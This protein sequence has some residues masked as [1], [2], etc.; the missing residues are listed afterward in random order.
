MNTPFRLSLRTVAGLVLLGASITAASTAALAAAG[1]KFFLD[2]PLAREPDPGDASHVQPFPVHLTWDLVSSLFVN[3]LQFGPKEDFD[4][5]P[6]TFESDCAKMDG[7]G[8]AHLLAPDEREM[9]PTRQ[10]YHV[11]PDPAHAD[12]LEG[13][14]RPGFFGGVATVV[15]KLFGI[16]QPRRAVRKEGLPQLMI[17]RAM[18]REFALPIEMSPARRSG[19]RTDWH[20]RRATATSAPPKGLRHPGCIA[21]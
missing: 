12:I 7:A 1:P 18:V 17:I 10:S 13:E 11:M 6:R 5:Y 2:D 3:R 16:V 9:Y 21:V 14:F 4:K 15:M 20:S 19:P 8:V